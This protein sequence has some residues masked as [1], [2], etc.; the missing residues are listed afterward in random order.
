MFYNHYIIG[1]NF[2]HTQNY[3]FNTR[4][5]AIEGKNKQ[6]IKNIIYNIYIRKHIILK[7]DV[8]LKNKRIKT[9]L[10]SLTIMG[11]LGFGSTIAFATTTPLVINSKD[12]GNIY[13]SLKQSATDKLLTQVNSTYQSGPELYRKFLEEKNSLPITLVNSMNKNIVAAPARILYVTEK[14]QSSSE[15]KRSQQSVQAFSQAT[16]AQ[17]SDSQTQIRGTQQSI[18]AFSPANQA[19]ESLLKLMK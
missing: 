14:Q 2:I 16:Q 11:T 15:I 1:I 10:F 7:G 19:P 9:M 8:N 12:T 4:N 5:N 6:I 13:A 17:S 18:A 3:A